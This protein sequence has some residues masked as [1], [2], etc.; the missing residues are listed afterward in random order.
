MGTRVSS[1]SVCFLVVACSAPDPGVEGLTR[2]SLNHDGG[3]T[4]DGAVSGD[5]GNQEGGGDSGSTQDSGSEASVQADAFTGAGAYAAS[6]PATTAAQY[7]TTNNVGVTPGLGVDCLGCHKMGGP[8]VVFLFGGTL[9]QDKA[10][11]MPATSKEIRVLDM[12]NVGY[13]GY[14]DTDGNFWYK[15]SNNSIA[16]PAMSGVRDAA[17]TALMVG[18]ITAANCNGCHDKNTTDPLHIP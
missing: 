2:G 3:S 4:L 1:W 5:A 10:G 18:T 17:Q 8:G 16:F 6:T 12:N 7:H 9:F 13:S 11:T 14:S 15:A